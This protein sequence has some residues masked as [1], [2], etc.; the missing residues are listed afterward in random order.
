MA[1]KY[2]SEWEMDC[3]MEKA[4]EIL[5]KMPNATTNLVAKQLGVTIDVARTVIAMV[6]HRNATVK[7]P[8]EK[9]RWG[10]SMQGRAN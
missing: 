10:D 8:L 9:H 2:Y 4:D 1:K 5:F 7:D 6:S 3:L